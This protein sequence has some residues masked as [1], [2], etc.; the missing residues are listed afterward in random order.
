MQILM[1]ILQVLMA[2]NRLNHAGFN[3]LKW[4]IIVDD[5]IIYKIGYEIYEYML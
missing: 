1:L 4:R 5:Y 2:K 3:V